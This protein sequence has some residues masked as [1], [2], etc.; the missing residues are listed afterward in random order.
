MLIT[1]FVV[2]LGSISYLLYQSANNNGRKA[3][4]NVEP[5]DPNKKIIHILYGTTTGT[6]KRFSSTLAKH[7]EK[8]CPIEVKVTDLKDYNE[9]TLGQEDI[10]L[11]VC[12]TWTGGV[13][14]E[15]CKRF[16][17]WIEDYAYDFRVSKDSLSK[18]RFAIFGLGGEIYDKNFCKTVSLVLLSFH[19]HI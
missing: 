4:K 11:F 10:V 5:R 12:S 19:S 15:S 3:I 2:V 13:A 18:V 14:P 17:D 8:K 1:S 7:I 6:A 16:F 9:E